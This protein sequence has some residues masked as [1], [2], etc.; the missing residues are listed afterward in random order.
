MF[1]PSSLCPF[2]LFYNGHG[3]GHDDLYPFRVRVLGR[4]PYRHVDRDL[5]PDLSRCPSHC[6]DRPGLAQTYHLLY[7]SGYHGEPVIAVLVV[8][9]LSRHLGEIEE[10]LPHYRHCCSLSPNGSQGKATVW[11]SHC[12]AQL[13]KGFCCLI[14][15]PG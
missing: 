2:H 1:D 4:V 6:H 9:L 12:G 11:V 5:F 7:A 13:R 15:Q 3:H 8:F 14:F 10:Y